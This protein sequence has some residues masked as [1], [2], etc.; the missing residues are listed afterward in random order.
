MKYYR[1]RE[2]TDTKQIGNTW[3][4]IQEAEYTCDPFED[5]KF[6]GNIGLKKVSFTPKLPLGKLDKRAKLTDLLSAVP[7][8]FNKRVVISTKLKEILI[9]ENNTNVQAFNNPIL[10]DKLTNTDYWLIN[11]IKLSNNKIDFEKSDLFLKDGIFLDDKIK[12]LNITTLKEYINEEKKVEEM[13]GFPFNLS[14]EK[15]RINNKSKESFFV[16]NN[17]YGGYGYYVSEKLKNEIENQKLTGL[18]FEE[19]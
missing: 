11:P 7:V 19:T 1:I 16:L 17:V 4:Q 8:G 10:V 14:F 5:K 12:K 2:S 18:E 6:I 15:I 13:G 9:S 3:P